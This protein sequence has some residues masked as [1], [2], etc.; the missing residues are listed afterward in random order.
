[1]MPTNEQQ[2]TIWTRWTCSLSGHFMCTHLGPENKDMNGI[3]ILQGRGE[4]RK[5][6][7]YCKHPCGNG[8]SD[9]TEPER[10]RHWGPLA[11][12]SGSIL[13]KRSY[14][15]MKYKMYWVSTGLWASAGST[16]FISCDAVCT[17]NMNYVSPSI[18]TRNPHFWLVNDQR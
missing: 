18:N 15:L 17:L 1:M 14:Q 7:R 6:I 2:V 9:T 13:H 10:Q 3:L 5:G 12:S 8:A 4:W 11:W 16:G